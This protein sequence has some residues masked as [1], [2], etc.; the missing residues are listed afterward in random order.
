MRNIPNTGLRMIPCYLHVCYEGV[1][2]LWAYEAIQEENG[3]NIK[4]QIL[5][6]SCRK[7]P[8]SSTDKI[9]PRIKWKEYQ[10]SSEIRVHV[11]ST[12]CGKH[13]VVIFSSIYPSSFPSLLPLRV[14]DRTP[15]SYVCLFRVLS[16]SRRAD[17]TRP[18]P[19]YLSDWR[20]I[21]KNG[22]LYSIEFLR[23]PHVE[24]LLTVHPVQPLVFSLSLLVR[25]LSVAPR[26]LSF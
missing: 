17:C 11:L 7:K 16:I 1:G 4:V 18:R 12:S 9:L 14:I 3:K 21:L 6:T 20:C 5:S 13:W 8:G 2:I 10:S 22:F 19:Y 25:P 24:H 26:F 23:I 15:L